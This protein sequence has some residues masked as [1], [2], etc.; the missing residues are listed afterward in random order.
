MG[1]LTMSPASY[2]FLCVCAIILF[3]LYRKGNVRAG[4]KLRDAVFFIE[5]SEK[6]LRPNRSRTRSGQLLPGSDKTPTR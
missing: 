3:A 5:A 1:A 6:K 2:F 4:F